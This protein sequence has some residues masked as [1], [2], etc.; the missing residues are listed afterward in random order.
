MPL[1]QETDL[2]SCVHVR[3]FPACV[4]L[5]MALETNFRQEVPRMGQKAGN[6]QP[7]KKENL[8]QSAALYLK[9]C[10]QMSWKEKGQ[11]LSSE[12]EMQE[13]EKE[14]KSVQRLFSA[15]AKSLSPE[16]SQ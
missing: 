11:T 15:Q 10:P 14:A 13:A 12:A 16:I 8:S 5:W 7:E 1:L 6:L 2:L 4:W 3:P 9:G